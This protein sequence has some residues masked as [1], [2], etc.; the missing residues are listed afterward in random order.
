M[1]E[2]PIHHKHVLVILLIIVTT[3]N[4]YLDNLNKPCKYLDS[5]NIT[6]GIKDQE[7]DSI[8]F[9][10]INYTKKLYDIYDYE[11]VNE[12]YRHQVA[13]HIRGCTCELKP[14]VRMCCPREK[15]FNG[16]N[17]VANDND[18]IYNL[19]VNVTS[20]GV[21]FSRENLLNYFNYVVGKPCHSMNPMEPAL[22]YRYDTWAL[23]EVIDCEII[24]RTYGNLLKS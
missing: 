4:A 10:G 22:Y 20:D 15:Y 8:M 24:S 11:F 18:T 17:C 6:D 5:I 14:C 3:C 9:D 23:F 13:S 16:T 21:H 12:S 2:V 1:A 7:T 19:S